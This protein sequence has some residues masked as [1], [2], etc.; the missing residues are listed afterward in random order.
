MEAI[1]VESV[2]FYDREEAKGN[3]LLSAS[4]ISF[5]ML[6]CLQ[7]NLVAHRH[8]MSMFNKKFRKIGDTIHVRKPIRF[9]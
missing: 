7:Q 6:E 8:E 5:V 3:R 1:N 2:E 4:E 9:R